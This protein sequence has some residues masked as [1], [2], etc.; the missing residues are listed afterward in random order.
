MGFVLGDG[1]EQGVGRAGDTGDG[2]DAQ[3]GV[4]GVVVADGFDLGEVGQVARAALAGGL[5]AD[6]GGELV[7]EGGL[8]DAAGDLGG[9]LDAGEGAQLVDGGGEAAALQVDQVG[10]GGGERGHRGGVFA[11]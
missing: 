7:G 9:E 6:G 8:Q 10:Q 1:V 3:A 2:V 5:V 4:A 11:A